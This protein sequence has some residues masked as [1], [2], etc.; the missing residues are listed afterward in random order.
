LLYIAEM[1]RWT[2]WFVV[3]TLLSAA[4][5][6]FAL[7]LGAGSLGPEP[8]DGVSGSGVVKAVAVLAMLVAAVLGAMPASRPW[9]AALF[10]P[11]AAAF[12][13][14]FFFTYDAYYAPTLRRYSDGGAASTWIFVVALVALA[15][16]V[17]TA[18]QPRLGR[19]MTPVVLIA[20]L[21]TT[22]FAGAGH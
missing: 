19:V 21:L 16:G 1:L 5:Y 18:S 6:E 11:A 15:D 10:G 9:P 4:A 17:L 7:A 12:L 14:S 13:V 2:G 20:V 22:L 3:V 8:G